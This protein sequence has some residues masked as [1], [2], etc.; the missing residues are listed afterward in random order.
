MRLTHLAHPAVLL[1]TLAASTA[2]VSADSWLYVYLYGGGAHH[3]TI[4][5]LPVT[6]DG[7]GPIHRQLTMPGLGR[8]VSSF[9]GRFLVWTV[10]TNDKTDVVYFDRRTGG[11][12]VLPDVGPIRELMAAPD[13]VRFYAQR[14]GRVN[15]LL[16]IE[17]TGIRIVRIA[18]AD[19]YSVTV[20]KVL[21]NGRLLG[22]Y[23]I[24]GPVYVFPFVVEIDP[25]TGSFFTVSHD[26]RTV[27]FVD[28]T[29]SRDGTRRYLLFWGE[30]LVI[31]SG[32]GE[33]LARRGPSSLTPAFLLRMEIDE[34]FGRVLVEEVSLSEGGEWDVYRVI[35]LDP[36]SLTPVP[37]MRQLTRLPRLH[38][39]PS[40]GMVVALTSVKGNANN[41]ASATLEAWLTA[42]QPA[43]SVTVD[44]GGAC[45]YAALATP[46]SEPTEFTATVDGHR[47]T[48]SW[49]EVPAV[50]G[51]EVEGG[52]STGLSDLAR[53]ST[54]ATP[55]LV[56]N[57]VPAGTYYVRVRAR[58]DV[59]VG[60]ASPEVVVVVP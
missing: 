36:L 39:D 30:L 42:D 53:L 8:P 38:A 28:M 57:D 34:I 41:C 50:I 20:W 45:A 48:L 16:V 29:Y 26:I 27:S 18:S 55:Q 14:A 11:T 32:T 33:I 10:S 2:N 6:R 25:L 3:P 40:Q 23:Q 51:Y 4:I 5:E 54:P 21:P 52:S 35:A 58:N 22:S 7:V 60:P 49:S 1:L 47:V 17:P 15:E 43:S 59:G 56:V 19:A 31:D 44:T 24:F 12:G 13:A 46:P 9:D 37:M